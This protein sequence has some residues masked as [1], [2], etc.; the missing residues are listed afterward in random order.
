MYGGRPLARTAVATGLASALTVPRKPR[1]TGRLRKSSRASTVVPGGWEAGPASTVAPART[2]TRKPGPLTSSEFVIRARWETEPMAWRAS[3]RKPRDSTRARSSAVR[4]LL[5]A[6]SATAPGVAGGHP[7]AVVPDPDRG[8]PAVHDV[9]LDPRSAGVQGVLNKLLHGA[10]RALDDLP[11]RDPVR[12]LG[13]QHAH[14][15]SGNPVLGRLF[16]DG[17][18]EEAHGASHSASPRS[19]LRPRLRGARGSRRPGP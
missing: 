11:C 16:G 14:P 12:H 15:A 1:R 19:P 8:D 13:R 3:P 4:I 10:R 18:G 9:H 2:L 17:P 5:V 7:V 6:C